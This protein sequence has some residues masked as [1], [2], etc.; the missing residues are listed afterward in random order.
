MT[1]REIERMLKDASN[2]ATIR[3]PSYLKTLGINEIALVKGKGNYCAVLVDLDKSELL[4]ILQG[5]TQ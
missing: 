3:K 4:A 1:T 2:N 5:R